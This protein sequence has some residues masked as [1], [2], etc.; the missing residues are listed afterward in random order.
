MS[1][2]KTVQPVVSPAATEQRLRV[3]DGA[4]KAAGDVIDQELPSVIGFNV[5]HY[6]SIDTQGVFDH[7]TKWVQWSAELK[8]EGPGNFLTFQAKRWIQTT[9]KPLPERFQEVD[10]SFHSIE[11]LEYFGRLAIAT[12]EKMRRTAEKFD[13]PIIYKDE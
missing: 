2:R 9:I 5:S 10:L 8:Y 12:A 1:N 3:V 4:F 11:E 13:L 6:E 7:T